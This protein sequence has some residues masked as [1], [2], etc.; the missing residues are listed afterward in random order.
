MARDYIPLNQKA[1]VAWMN[2]FLTVLN[3]NLGT[4]GLVA[5]DLTPLTNARNDF[6]TK[7]SAF[8]SAETAYRSAS[9]AKKTS[10]TNAEA[11]FRQMA[12]RINRHPNMTNALRQQLGLNV[13]RPRGRRG[14]GPEIPGVRLEVDAGRVIIH[15]GT[16]PDDETRNGKPEWALGANIYVKAE[17][18]LDYRLL[19][20][21]T[22]SPY[23]WEY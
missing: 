22:A 12:Q 6:Q 7:L 15:F 11:L 21:D 19:A 5:A 17:D 3:A 4:F 20:F 23:V 9:E 14:V 1:I 16:N 10:R 2:N 13:P 8:Q 18:E